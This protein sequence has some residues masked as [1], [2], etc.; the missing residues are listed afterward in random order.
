MLDL[1][2]VRSQI[3]WLMNNI[4]LFVEEGIWGG[5]KP[6]KNKLK[7][8]GKGWESEVG[9]ERKWGRRNKEWQKERTEKGEWREKEKGGGCMKGGDAG[10]IE[11][12]GRWDKKRGGGWDF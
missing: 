9:T 4:V 8:I 12:V 10:E 6:W 2:K 7:M 11:R 1:L 3:H 5:R